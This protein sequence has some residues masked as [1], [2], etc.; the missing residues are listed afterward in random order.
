MKDSK[1]ERKRIKKRELKISKKEGNE[2][3]QGRRKGKRKEKQKLN[4]K[5]R[6]RV[7]KFVERRK[8]QQVNALSEIIGVTFRITYHHN[9]ECPQFAE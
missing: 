2:E 9:M 1:G 8:D 5:K 4:K 7:Y 3:K 6:E